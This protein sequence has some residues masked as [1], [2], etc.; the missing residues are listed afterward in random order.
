MLILDD[1]FAELDAG[2]RDRLAAL[3]ADAEQVMVTAAVP[4]D[5]PAVLAGARFTVGAGGSPVTAR[6]AGGTGTGCGWRPRRWPRRRR[7]RGPG[8]ICRPAWRGRTDPMIPNGPGYPPPPGRTRPGRPGAA[9]RREDPQPLAS[10][11]GGLL[12]TG[13]AAAGSDGFGVWPVGGDRRR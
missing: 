11:I 13:L 8:A 12:D 3:V 10:A 6:L 4:A 5:V 2:R 7:T 1:V 9:T